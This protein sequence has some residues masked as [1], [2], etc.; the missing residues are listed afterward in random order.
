MLKSLFCVV[1][2]CFMMQNSYALKQIK[3]VSYFASLRANETNVR[4]GPGQ[5]YPIKFTFKLKAIPVKVVNEY[6]N[7]LEIEDYEGDAGWITQSL[8]TKK[9]MLIIRNDGGLT[10]MRSKNKDKSKMIYRLE[11]N[12]IG[13]Y[14]GCEGQRCEVKI[15]GKRGWVNKGE[16]FG[17]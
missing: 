10:E 7:W 1:F 5:N 4:S 16:L 14:Q 12:V 17:W 11:N 13:E 15:E 3:E 8:V 6:D 9:R 2:L